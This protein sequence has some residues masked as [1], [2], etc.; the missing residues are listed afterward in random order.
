MPVNNICAFISLWDKNLGPRII[1]IYPKSIKP[2]YDL[3]LISSKVFFAFQDFFYT[4]SERTSIKKTYFKLTI[5]EINR[6]AVILLDALNKETNDGTQKVFIIVLL[7]PAH[8]SDKELDNFKDIIYEIDNEYLNSGKVFFDKYISKIEENYSLEEKIKDSNILIDET[9]SLGKAILDFKNGIN[10]FSKNQ[11]EKSYIYL[12]KAYLKF[13]A[14]NN[15]KLILESLYFLSSTLLQLNKYN[16][17]Q[18][19]IENLKILSDELKSEKYYE[20]SLFMAGYCFY[21]R[22]EYDKALE[23]FRKLESTE[24]H[25]INKFNFFFFY[26]RILRLKELYSDAL[27]SLQKALKVILKK[28]SSKQIKEKKAQILVEL[29]HIN[30]SIATKMISLG[31]LNKNL[32]KSY[33]QKAIDYYEDSINILKE[34]NNFNGLISIYRLIGNINEYL[35]NYDLSIKNYRNGLHFAEEINDIT[36]RL[37]IFNLIIQNLSKLNRYDTI[38]KETDEMLSKILAYAYLD[39]FTIANYHQYLGEALFKLGKYKDALSEL[40]ISLNIYNKFDKPVLESLIVLEKIIEIYDNYENLEKNKYISYYKE[41]YDELADKIQKSKLIQELGFELLK[42]I[43][44]FWIFS[45]DGK[46]L[47]SY[48]PETHFNPELFGGFLTALQSFSMEIASQNLKSITIGANKYT[49]FSEND[50]FFVLGR[51]NIKSS[52]VNIE[53]TLKIIHYKFWENYNHIFKDFDGEIDNFSNF[54]ELIEDKN[55]FDI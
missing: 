17:A 29:G 24:L 10:Q 21:K 40:L 27:D 1:A 34:I 42:D 38:I 48:S 8:L 23:K 53:R 35:G 28:E 25:N 22:E 32:F 54:F 9:Y 30:Y 16:I 43:K 36:S 20:N 18:I 26:G 37:Q 3:E 47:Y 51:S 13:S 12:K 39:L 15:I 44:E 7:F 5:N 4:E 49:F 46:Q 31:K 50:Q 45:L 19:Y 11:F 55:T 52:L 6:K 33:L 2:V 41:Q 14:E